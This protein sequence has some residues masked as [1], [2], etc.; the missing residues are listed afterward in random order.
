MLPRDVTEG[1]IVFGRVD[2]LQSNP[3]GT[4][5]IEDCDYIAVIYLDD[6]TE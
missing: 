1:L 6:L 2:A 4:V 5:Q 3:H